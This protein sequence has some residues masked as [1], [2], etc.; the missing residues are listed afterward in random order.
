MNRKFVL[1]LVLVLGSALVAALAVRSF[2]NPPADLDQLQN[3]T[4]LKTELGLTDEQAA[5]IQALQKEYT[6]EVEACCGRHCDARAKLSE[7]MFA[8]N[9]TDQL[10]STV[11]SMCRA[12]IDSEM[13]TIAHIRKVRDSL[14]PDQQKKYEQM[15]TGCVCGSCPSGFQHAK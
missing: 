7:A 4:Y 5:K 9:D 1:V 13:A 8:G 6:G 2:A 15:V 12:Q 3:G 11:E 10:R 14:T